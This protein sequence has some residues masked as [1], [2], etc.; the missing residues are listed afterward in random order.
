[1]GADGLIFIEQSDKADFK[2]QF[3][4]A[5]GSI[6]EMC[7]NGGRCAARYAYLKGIA[8][9]SLT[10]ETLA[11]I[12][13]AQVNEKR[14]KLEMTKPHSLKLDEPLVL[15]EKAYTV[16][17]LN[18]GVPHAVLFI[19][20]VETIDVVRLGRAI[21]NHPHFA[22]AGTNANFVRLEKNS[23][24]SIRTYERGVED[25]T[26]ACGTG[27]VASALIAAFKGMVKSPVSV[28]T[29]GGEILTV[30]FEIAGKEVKGVFFEGDVHIIY[31]AEMW[32]EAWQ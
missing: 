27:T 13:S 8:G 30:H 21:R 16:S 15:E 32:E 12:L 14:V 17:S 2:W 9:H 18:T 6:A 26:L 7:G 11:G 22:P 10:F 4:N 20:D 3:F 24:L 19:N 31:E 28:S 29:R 23:Q 5:D 25:E 1:V